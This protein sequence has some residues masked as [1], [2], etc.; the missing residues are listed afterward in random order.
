MQGYDPFCL[1][2]PTERINDLGPPT[3]NNT[4]PSQSQ[5]LSPTVEKG[6]P[7]PLEITFLRHQVVTILTDAAKTILKWQFLHWAPHILTV[8]YPHEQIHF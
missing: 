4:K 8:H 3:K 2:N 6:F 7:S 1:V 5:M